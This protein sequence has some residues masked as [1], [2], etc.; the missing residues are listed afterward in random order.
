[1][2]AGA[3]GRQARTTGASITQSRPPRRRTAFIHGRLEAGV[4]DDQIA[5]LTVELVMA[6]ALRNLAAHHIALGIDFSLE[7]DR[8]LFT[9]GLRARRVLA[10]N[11]LAVLRLNG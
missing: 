10:E 3:T 11:E 7:T 6:A 9:G 4:V 1:M 5:C 8:S 2:H